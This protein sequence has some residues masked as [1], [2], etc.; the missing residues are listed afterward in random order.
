VHEKYRAFAL[1]A[2]LFLLGAGILFAQSPRELRTGSWVSEKIREGEEQWFSVR[3]PGSGYIIVETAGDL[4][5]C[6]DAYDAARNKIG[7]DDDGGD[8]YNARLEIYAEAGKTYLFKLNCFEEDESG[9]YRIRASFETIPPD[10]DRN[11]DRSRALTLKLGE[12]NQ[13]YLRSQ[14]E[15]RWF[16]YDIPRP[17]TLFTVQTRG[18]LDTVL[19][20]YDAGGNHIEED[21]D[22]GEGEN[23]LISERLGPGTVYIQVR[24]YDG[25]MGRCTLHAEIR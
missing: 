19:S 2:G 11:T 16:R 10:T 14:S 18:N 21:D 22:S 6:L 1:A 4:D 7:E 13:V 8:D 24:E 3:A 5:T 23:A 17:E 12:P 25:N 9:V 15:S 20:L